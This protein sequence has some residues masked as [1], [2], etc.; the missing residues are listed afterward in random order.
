MGGS[1]IQGKVAT[2][3]FEQSGDTAQ[4]GG[5]AATVRADNRG[6]FTLRKFEGQILD[7]GLLAVAEAHVLHFEGAF[8]NFFHR[9]L[10][11]ISTAYVLRLT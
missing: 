10:S 8:G 9:A 1:I 4:Q 11:V 3:G 7:D 5:L 6:D 2:E